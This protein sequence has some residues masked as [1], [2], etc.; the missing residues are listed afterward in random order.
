MVDNIFPDRRSQELKLEASVQLRTMWH[1]LCGIIIKKIKG[2]HQE[3]CGVLFS[4]SNNGFV[5]FRTFGGAR[6]TVALHCSRST[7][8]HIFMCHLPS[9]F[10]IYLLIHL[11]TYIS[12]ISL[13][14]ANIVYVLMYYSQ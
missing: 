11:L 6:A 12:L 13:Y 2:K 1:P 7:Q 10:Y 14:G 8:L 9:T 5:S 4:Y 3:Y